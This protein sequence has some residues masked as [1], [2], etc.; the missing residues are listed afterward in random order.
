MNRLLGLISVA[1]AMTGL[2][3]TP[4]SADDRATCF[5]ADGPP[6]SAIA[7]CG[8]LIASGKFKKPDLARVYLWRADAWSRKR[9]HDNA[10]ADSNESIRLDPKIALAYYIRG[11]SFSARGEVFR[12]AADFDAVIRLDP[13]FANAYLARGHVFRQQSQGDRAIADYSEAIRLNPR[14]HAAYTSRGLAYWEKRDYD[15]AIQDESEAIRLQPQN[16]AYYTQ[17]GFFYDAKGEFDNAVA[18]FRKALALDPRDTRAPALIKRLEQQIASRSSA[19]S[20]AAPPSPANQPAA[21]AA[22]GPTTTSPSAPG[23]AQP[24]RQPQASPQPAPKATPLTAPAAT[25][26]ADVRV[27]LIVGNGNYRHANRLPNPANDA[28]DMADVLR[29]LGFD[30]VEG[31]D[32]DKRSLEDKVREFGRKLDRANIAL[33]FYAGHGIQVGG[34]NYLIPIDAKLE[35]PGDLTF[36]TIDVSQVLA[37]MEAEQRVNLVFLDAC[38]DNPLARSFASSLG[39]RSVS[40][41]RGLATIQSAL[42]TMISYATQPD[43]VALDGEGRNSPFTAALLKHL[44]TPGVEIGSVMK[45]VRADVVQAT[46]GK[47]VPWDH[48]SLIGD[49]VLAQR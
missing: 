30:V 36:D 38:R 24:E 46:R 28:S 41:G 42:G 1:L 18:D 3:G 47:Q 19:N 25:R 8:R 35:R 48:S 31:R 39:T 10:V 49:V 22:A 43:A 21:Q 20:S 34:R 29:K 27:A 12:A 44:A 6:D 45:R 16:S 2:V 9:D 4:A 37:Q 32:L 11:Q 40:V 14:D 15:R 13:K 7:A 5:S 26:P 23:S 17:R 33:F